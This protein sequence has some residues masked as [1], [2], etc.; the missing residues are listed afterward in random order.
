MLRRLED[1]AAVEIL[2]F[3]GTAAPPLHT[4]RFFEDSPAGKKR[5]RRRKQWVCLKISSA[6]GLNVDVCVSVRRWAGVENGKQVKAK[7][8]SGELQCAIFDPRLVSV[9]SRAGNFLL[10]APKFLF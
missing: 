1:G 6:E 10:R 9:V 5:G 3:T 2:F 8:L 4:A 7:L